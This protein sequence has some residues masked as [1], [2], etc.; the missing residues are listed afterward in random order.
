MSS[1]LAVQ[2]VR[3]L[4]KDDTEEETGLGELECI[5]GEAGGGIRDRTDLLDTALSEFDSRVDTFISTFV[6]ASEV[7]HSEVIGLIVVV[8]PI[9]GSGVGAADT[10]LGG[11]LPAVV[12]V[13]FEAGVGVTEEG[14]FGV[15]DI[16]RI[17]SETNFSGQA[18][19]GKGGE[20]KVLHDDEVDEETTESFKDTEHTVCSGHEF[21]GDHVFSLFSGGSDHDTEFS[22]F[23]GEGDGGD[24]IGT[25]TDTE[26]E[27]SGDGEWES[28]DEESEEGNKLGDV[29]GQGVH[30]RLLQV[31]ED[32]STFFNTED[33]SSE[34]ITQ[35]DHISGILSD[36][37]T[38]DT[39]GNTD[40]GL[41]DSWGVI[42]TI[43]CDGDN[44]SLFLATL[45][46]DKL[47]GRG[48]SGED[49]SWLF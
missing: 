2:G 11:I 44:V 29:G 10:A 32:S 14:S 17:R 23:G 7:V 9:G 20:T 34:I 42:D 4:S 38:G 18:E 13:F 37:G 41:L 6:C 24:N 31:I 49:D 15:I 19:Q 3:N 8:Q 16:L 47:L 21:S 5:G 26:H 48:S 46:D 22:F 30:D 39:H 33:N 36:I 40:I 12:A 35:Q 28:D 25:D 43:T 1:G 45:D 27:E